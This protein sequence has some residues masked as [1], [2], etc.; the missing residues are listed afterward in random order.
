MHQH[1]LQVLNLIPFPNTSILKV[2]HFKMLFIYIILKQKVH[3]RF[4]LTITPH[5]KKPD[6]KN[7]VDS[8]LII[9]RF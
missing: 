6:L 5:P 7:S 9:E 2:I 4:H 1:L 3:I 8:C